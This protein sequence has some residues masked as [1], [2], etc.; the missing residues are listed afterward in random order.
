MAA[1]SD[2]SNEII[3]VGSGESHTINEFAKLL[4]GNIKYISRGV[5][6]HPDRVQADISKIGRLLGWVPQIP[7]EEGVKIVLENIDSWRE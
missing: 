3:N 7:F 4:G 1:E 6:E 5:S 2:L